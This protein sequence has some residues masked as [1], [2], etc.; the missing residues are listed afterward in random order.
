[1]LSW[2]LSGSRKVLEPYFGVMCWCCVGRHVLSLSSRLQ[3][4]ARDGVPLCGECL[5]LLSAVPFYAAALVLAA[6][7]AGIC[8]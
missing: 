4:S 7:A 3:A 6:Q 5:M 8:A 1:M 2:Y